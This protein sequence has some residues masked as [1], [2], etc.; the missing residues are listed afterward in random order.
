M[1]ALGGHQ[2]RNH[3]PPQISRRGAPIERRPILNVKK[4][5][6][7]AISEKSGVGKS[8][9][10]GTQNW[11]IHETLIIDQL[12]RNA[13]STT[14]RLRVGILDLDVFGPSIPKLMGLQNSMEPELTASGAIKPLTNHGVPCMS[15]SFLLPRT[16]DYE[17]TPIVWRGL[18][19]QKAVQQ[20]LFDVDWTGGNGV[21]LDVLV[22]DTPPGTGDVP[23]TLGQLVQS[24]VW[25]AI[26]V[27]TPQVVALSDVRKG[28]AMFQKVSVPI[29]G[30][31]LNQAYFTCPTCPTSHS[32]FGPPDAFRSTAERL[33]LDVL[34]ELPLVPHVSMSSDEGRPYM[35]FQHEKSSEVPVGEGKDQWLEGMMNTAQAVWKKLTPTV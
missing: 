28:I 20:L 21:G 23:L 24:T 13:S 26:I 7:V 14:S 15:M 27:S 10:A 3:A 30:L 29:A 1:T 5:V 22:I 33:M 18:M 11:R 31:V 32:L 16:A 6:A 34:A 25:G 8:T 2:S 12:L 19:V 9:M 4:V 17:D 35:L